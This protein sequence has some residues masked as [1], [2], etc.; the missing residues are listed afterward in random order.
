MRRRRRGQ[1]LVETALILAAF[2][3][4]LL[5]MVGIGQ[6]IFARQTLAERAHDAARWGAMNHYDPAAIRNLV[7]YGTSAPSGDARP[8]LGLSSD[9]VEV[10]NPG[11]PGPE[12][13]VSVAIPGQGIR[14]V[15]PVE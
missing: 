7:L 6:M 12:C 4:L 3:L 15:E 8:I 9:G 11:C 5:G 14:S 13:M 10:R 1:A 2:M